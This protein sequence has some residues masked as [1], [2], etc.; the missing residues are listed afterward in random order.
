MGTWFFTS[1]YHPWFH[2]F[3]FS[4][5]APAK[6]YSSGEFNSHFRERE[7]WVSNQDLLHEHR[8]FFWE[9]RV[10]WASDPYLDTRTWSAGK[11]KNPTVT[12]TASSIY[13]ILYSGWGK[14]YFHQLCNFILLFGGLYNSWRRTPVVLL[15]LL[16]GS[17]AFCLWHILS[18]SLVTLRIF[19][20]TSDLLL[21]PTKNHLQWFRAQVSMIFIFPASIQYLLTL[22]FGVSSSLT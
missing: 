11:Y 3:D 12:S 17:N 19:L 13:Q 1:L 5:S 4:L 6:A 20:L 10:D 16:V 15:P 18:L 21:G 2:P 7:L 9:K 8:T 22:S 14:D